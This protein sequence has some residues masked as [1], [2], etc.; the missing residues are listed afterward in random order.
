MLRLPTSPANGV[1]PRFPS[2][3]FLKPRQAVP[4]PCPGQSPG[5]CGLLLLPAF[6][7]F[8]L[9]TT[10]LESP[11]LPCYFLSQHPVSSLLASLL[12][13]ITLCNYT[14]LRLCWYFLSPHPQ[15][16]WVGRDKAFLVHCSV[17]AAL[18]VVQ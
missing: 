16:S 12:L 6:V 4:V 11:S 8:S 1:R 15:L 17:L 18:V 14:F 9:K 7:D 3:T 13:L 2:P 5:A 10:S